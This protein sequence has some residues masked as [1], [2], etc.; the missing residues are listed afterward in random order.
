MDFYELPLDQNMQ[1]LTQHGS[2]SFPIQYYVD[3]PS[4]FSNCT[5]PLHWHPQLEFWVAN[6]GPASVQIGKTSFRLEEGFGIFINANV[7]HSFCQAEPS[8]ILQCPNIV[9]LD[10]LLAPVTSKIYQSYVRPLTTNRLLPYIL[11]NPHKEWQKKILMLLENIFQIFQTKHLKENEK[12]TPILPF[13]A[14][15]TESACFE[16]EV[17]NKLNQLWQIL[18]TH[19]EDIPLIHSP[20][21]EQ[22]L[23]IRTQKMLAFIHNHYHEQISLP[24]IADSAGIS[25]S[26]AARCFQSYLHTSPIN[27]LLGYR[28]ERAKWALQNSME[29]IAQISQG[30]G[31]QSPSYF[32]KTFRRQTGFTPKQ[33]RQQN[34]LSPYL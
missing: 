8:Q 17:Q 5:I 28:I 15:D 27:Y 4:H 26:E 22:L 30:C 25:I 32:G 18:Y 21:N 19:Q 9:F 3:E 10:E 16:M 31:F 11:L 13:R 24:E 33:Y 14:F 29:T 12:N 7:L 23:Q 2:P 20:K 34:T 1:E 6:G